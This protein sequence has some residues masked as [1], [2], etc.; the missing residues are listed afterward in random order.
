MTTLTN[1]RSWH[2]SI[3]HFSNELKLVPLTNWL[4]SISK[5]YAAFLHWHQKIYSTNSGKTFPI[6]HWESYPEGE[7]ALM[8]SIENSE[9]WSVVFDYF[10]KMK[11]SDGC[12]EM[13]AETQC[14]GDVYVRVEDINYFSEMSGI[15]KEFELPAKP[16]TEQTI[17]NSKVKRL[18]SNEQREVIEIVIKKTG[19]LTNRG[20]L[21]A[22]V[23]MAN[24]PNPPKPLLR[25]E[26]EN[27]KTF[28]VWEEWDKVANTF[29]GKRQNEKSALAQIDRA[30]AARHNKAH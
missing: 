6:Y 18:R 25:T 29:I 5:R 12:T 13:I 10:R 2:K 26:S 20:V 19:E 30:L 21:R 11:D 23:D 15:E 24:Q 27:G 7:P 3:I 22:L 8:N 4:V 1:K 28:I 14:E 17:E 16:T 9:Y